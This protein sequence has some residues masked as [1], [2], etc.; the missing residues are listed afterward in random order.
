MTV[1]VERRRL[2]ASGL[3]VSAQ[4]VGTMSWGPSSLWG[5]GKTH[6]E[7]DVRSAYQSSVDA[8][9]DFFDTAE[10]YA[11]GE[12]ERL[13][14]GFVREDG[15]PAV[16]ATKFAPMHWSAGA[17]RGALD[18]SLRRLGTESVDLYQ[19]HTPVPHIKVEA[20]MDAMADAFHADKIRAV[21]VSNYSP[22]LMR[23][24]HARLAEHGI[25]LASNEVHYSLLHRNPERNGV[26]EACRELDV[27]LIAASPLEMGLLTGKYR[28]GEAPMPARRR[29]MMLMT[30]LDPAGGAQGR[31]R[32]AAGSR[33]LHRAAT[34]PLFAA[35]DEIA[36][37]HSTTVQAV[38]LNWLLCADELVIP[39]PG[40]KNRR[41]AEGARASLGW[42]LTE[43]EQARIN[44][45]A[46]P[47]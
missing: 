23:R 29:L 28:G 18:A 39:I 10:G 32:L 31:S 26:L 5:Y 11:H 21:G 25:P 27:T 13:L 17:L 45:A 3:T 15:R 8:G 22:D 34:E 20:L 35:L 37:A 12:S 16:I 9:I 7:D 2:G 4:G 6:T 46:A 42:R 19:I 1:D 47:F 41:Q 38:A 14:G 43:S 24:A 36:A 44:E 33:K 40:A 30:G